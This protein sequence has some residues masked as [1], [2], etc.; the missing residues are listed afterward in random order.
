[1]HPVSTP[2]WPNRRRRVVLLVLAACLMVHPHET[3][4][5]GVRTESSR[6]SEQHYRRGLRHVKNAEYESAEREYRQ[7]IEID[8]TTIRAHDGLGFLY[9]LQN[10]LKQAE[11]EIGRAHV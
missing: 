11:K 2:N 8:S 5:Q 9:A 3:R 10:R 1:M 6:R 4:G 7:A